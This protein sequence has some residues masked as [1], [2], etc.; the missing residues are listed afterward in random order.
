M[1]IRQLETYS[2]LSQLL[3]TRGWT[4]ADLARHLE[5]NAV[6]VDRKTLYR[7]AGSSSLGKTDLTIV[8][9]ICDILGVGLD[10][11][12][13]FAA[14]LPNGESDEYWELSEERVRRLNE[15][16]RKN[17]DGALEPG[18]R[19][20]LADLVAEYETLA[21]HN[22]QVRLWREES[23]RFGEAQSRAART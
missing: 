1:A 15:L 23:S 10:D 3:R 13:R 17:N 22:A 19:Q 20:E 16:G 2:R 7:L 8:R 9:L 21:L 4:V 14:P 18:E 6:H 12:F 5:A 11:F